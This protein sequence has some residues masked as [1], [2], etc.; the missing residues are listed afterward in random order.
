MQKESGKGKKKKFE[1]ILVIAIILVVII[2]VLVLAYIL[3]LVEK[4]EIELGE[5]VAEVS[6]NEDKNEV[7]LKV[8]NVD[9][10]VEKIKFIFVDDKN[11]NYTF[12]TYS[13]VNEFTISA[14][15]AGLDSFK[16]IAN[17]S[18][19]FEYKQNLLP[20]EVEIP[21]PDDCISDC[22]GKQCGDNGCEGSCGSCTTGKKCESG[23]CINEIC[24]PD[25]TS[26]TCVN[27][28]CGMQKNNCENDVNCSIVNREFCET[29]VAKSKEEI[30]GSWKCGNKIDNCGKPV[31]CGTCASGDC[32][33]GVCVP[34]ADCSQCSSSNI[35]CVDDTA[36]PCQNYTTIQSAIDA[37][38]SG[39]TIL[40]NSGTYK[41][42]IQITKSDLKIKGIGMPV[43]DGNGE[44]NYGFYSASADNILIE[45]FEI[46]N[47]LA[48]GIRF[49]NMSQEKWT[50]RNNKIHHIGKEFTDVQHIK[51]IY[52]L[53][54]NHLIENNIIYMIR[55]GGESMGIQFVGSHSNIKN[56]TIYLVRKECMRIGGEG[57][58]KIS[59]NVTIENNILY[60]C[61]FGIAYSEGASG[62]VKSFNNYVY[63][64]ASGVNPKH[65]NCN[66]QNLYG[67][68]VYWH[69]TI[70]GSLAES[71]R[72]TG[73]TP[74]INCVDVKN[75]I[76]DRSGA[77]DLS[78]FIFED[79]LGSYDI[80][81]DGN[82][83][84][85]VG[86]Y[87]KYYYSGDVSNS[88][89]DKEATSV[90]EI[91]LITNY[92]NH[93][94]Y[95][96]H[97]KSFDPKLN[98]LLK[99]DLDYPNT[100][101]AAKGSID[102]SGSPYGKQ[103]GARGLKQTTPYFAEIPLDA[104]DASIREDL[105]DLSVDGT[106]FEWNSG[107]DRSPQWIIYDMGSK[108]SFTYI[109]Y[110][111][112]FDKMESNLRNFSISVSDSSG[113]STFTNQILKSINDNRGS[114]YIYEFPNS[115]SARYIKFDL[116]KNNYDNMKPEDRATWVYDGFEFREIRVGNLVEQS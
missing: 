47:Q 88:L 105:M 48:N 23:I 46:K 42:E 54:K 27:N 98:N 95:E 66:Y 43:I 70:Y 40:V 101:D 16:N 35:R 1:I 24:T 81:I 56:N 73:D 10:S 36:G 7:S 92:E 110:Y 9:E 32:A 100:S 38:S 31:D 13:I 2:L 18:A 86:S 78:G 68:N 94:P 53:G 96:L 17:V 69:N 44:K 34:P 97:G 83:Y 20:P 51:G 71:V 14:K 65:T 106:E 3:S 45:G 39:D 116:I 25:L 111:P 115:V 90:A 108:K 21:I 58:S 41:Q 74:R 80:S 29:C 8:N 89:D 55:N 50:I 75:N 107:A 113:S 49:N 52:A 63:K 64:M 93:A 67:R 6:L 87:P 30:C 61:M 77:N 57:S 104:I 85:K 103:L 59:V 99:G 4:K 15:E 112:T 19:E 62:G 28:I 114:M 22:A 33:S 26:I 79:N 91:P 82:L 76:F 5:N 60:Y 109:I 72:I 37:A 12:E 84:H 11:K 102:L